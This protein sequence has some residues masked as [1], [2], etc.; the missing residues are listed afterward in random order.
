GDREDAAEEVEVPVALHVPEVHALGAV[1][2]QRLVA[3]ELHPVRH[4]VEDL[5]LP[6]PQLPRPLAGAPH[7]LGGR[8][9]LAHALLLPRSR[10]GGALC[11]GTAV[12]LRVRPRT[13]QMPR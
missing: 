7:A 8:R 11:A 2:G 9:S 12:W 6:G 4:R 3:V 13:Y 1:D 10:H 5:L